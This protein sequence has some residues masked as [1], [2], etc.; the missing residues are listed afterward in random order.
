M[1]K[2]SSEALEAYKIRIDALEIINEAYLAKIEALE[3]LN[4]NLQFLRDV[5]MQAQ[6]GSVLNAPVTSGHST[7]AL[8]SG[9]KRGRGRPRKYPV[10][11]TYA[12]Q[13][14]AGIAGSGEKR[15]RG[16]PRKYPVG[17]ANSGS[18]SGAV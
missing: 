3:L 10:G 11:T 1:K 15:G 5:K 2:E 17:T 12:D 4:R 14:R 16:R 13:V 8:V 18:A 9:E 7:S 6:K